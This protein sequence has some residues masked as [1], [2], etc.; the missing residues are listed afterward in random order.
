MRL[1]EAVEGGIGVFALEGEIDLNFAPALRSLFRSKLKSR[2]PA[3]I[4]DLTGVSYI[5][6]TGISA[7]LEY[8]RDAAAHK[9]LL[10]L[11]GLNEKLQEIFHIVQLDKAI[12]MFTTA[13]AASAAIR[14]GAI[15][16]PAEAL[17]HRSEA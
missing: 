5:D 3:L 4:L 6:S 16:P 11:C 13:R 17:F 2:C 7:I 14:S 9:G 15:Q 1:K 8:F 10:C 12:P